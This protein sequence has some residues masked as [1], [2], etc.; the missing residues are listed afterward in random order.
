V[1]TIDS[2]HQP[3]GP[4]SEIDIFGHPYH[5]LVSAVGLGQLLLPNGSLMTYRMPSS[6][7][8]YS[9]KLHGVPTVTRTDEES[10]T[11]MESGFQWLDGIVLSGET[12]QFYGKLLIDSGSPL[13]NYSLSWICKNEVGRTFRISVLSTDSVSPLVIDVQPFG[14]IGA[15]AASAVRHVISVSTSGPIPPW[16]LFGITDGGRRVLIGTGRVGY[17]L[18]SGTVIRHQYFHSLTLAAE[19]TLID[20]IDDFPVP[21]F[22][23]LKSY[24]ECLG[25]IGGSSAAS[26]ASPVFKSYLSA[27]EYDTYTIVPVADAPPPSAANVRTAK[28]GTEESTATT[29]ISDLILSMYYESGAVNYF[30]VSALRVEEFKRGNVHTASGSTAAAYQV[31][32][33]IY[34]ASVAFKKGGTVI[35]S[36]SWSGF[37]EAAR[38]ANAE[39]DGT[40]PPELLVISGTTIF[41]DPLGCIPSWNGV[42]GGD[43]NAALR[44]MYLP[45][46]NQQTT[47]TF[48]LLFFSKNLASV[49]HKTASNVFSY[50]NVHFASGSVAGPAPVMPPTGKGPSVY[51][52]QNPIDGTVSYG[53][54]PICYV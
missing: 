11:D 43:L 52:A 12:S 50:G 45:Q 9:Y 48:G 37:A 36:E 41:S 10:A 7:D 19:V 40:L 42:A 46:I 15:E 6:A 1:T 51:A 31:D 8:C 2:I 16:K 28:I 49:I 47:N 27:P 44:E 54:A 53:S 34:D 35:H 39:W 21:N 24:T 26:A 14:E 5:G 33:R 22:E 18:G 38:V 32:T 20:G 30:S 13:I 4:L 17:G 23:V 3:A 25:V 29:S